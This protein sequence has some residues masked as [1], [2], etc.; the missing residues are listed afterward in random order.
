MNSFNVNREGWYDIF[1]DDALLV[2][3]KGRR[4]AE[5]YL[6]AMRRGSQRHWKMVDHDCLED[7]RV[8]RP[9]DCGRERRD[10]PDRTE[11]TRGY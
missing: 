4:W 9:S 3:I 11:G 1:V 10:S 2:S 7:I 5:M 6:K 8:V